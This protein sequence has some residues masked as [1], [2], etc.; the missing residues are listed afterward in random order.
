MNYL[1]NIL[2]TSINWEIKDSSGI[3]FTEDERRH[4]KEYFNNSRW[5]FVET[6]WAH[7]YENSWGQF[8][9]SV[10]NKVNAGLCE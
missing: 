4:L 2:S 9:Q 1:I 5:T 7:T 3:K 6:E 8:I 10:E